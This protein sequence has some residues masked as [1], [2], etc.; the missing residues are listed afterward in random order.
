MGCPVHSDEPTDESDDDGSRGIERRS[1]L[2]SALVIGGAS[3]L[4]TTVGLYG[5][6]EEAAADDPVGVAERA[7]RQHAWQ[8]FSVFDESREQAVSPPHS[9]ALLV[10]YERPGEPAY[11]HRREVATT[12]RKLEEA[13]AWSHEGL[14]FTIGYSP[15]YFDRFDESLPD[16]LNPDGPLAKP[17]LLRARDLIDTEGVTLDRE[18]PVA[19]EYDA[20]IHM[21]SDNVQT[22][23]AAEEALWGFPGDGSR[24]S[25]N[26]VDFSEANLDGIFTKPTSYPER[27]TAHAG[28]EAVTERLEEDTEFDASRIHDDAELSMGFVDIYRNSNPRETAA[29][30]VEGQRLVDPKPPR[31][32]AQGSVEHISHLDVNLSEKVGDDD[33]GWYDD[34]DLEERRAQMF[35]PHHTDEN[36]GDVGEHLGNSNAPG[37]IPM[38]DISQV[39]NTDDST[40]DLREETEPDDADDETDRKLDVAERVEDDAREYGRIGHAQK[41]ARAR[42]DLS[43]RLTDDAEERL[44]AGADAPHPADEPED[45]VPGH[46]DDQEAEPVL[47]RRDGV[48]TS[49]DQPGNMFLALMRFNPYMVYMRRAMNGVDFDTSTFGLPTGE[50]EPGF[51]HGNAGDAGDGEFTHDEVSVPDERNGIL[52]YVTTKSRGNFLVPPITHRALP[53]PEPSTPDVEVVKDGTTYLVAVDLNS[54][55]TESGYA[56]QPERLL[57]ETVRFGYYRHVNRGGGATPAFAERRGE[58]GR[59]VFG[60]DAAETELG[61]DDR[62]R[63]RLVGKFE[64][65]RRPIFATVTVDS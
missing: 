42:F 20:A 17:A 37:D 62:T 48:S 54:N 5:M 4:S 2:K 8:A 11:E 19:D 53:Y 46:D 23:L 50:G 13:F 9:M 52:D 34:H 18:D 44:D 65:T 59:F 15:E 47:L 24:D 1:F 28:N 64:G 16:G 27:R 57:D 35:S 41:C 38:R 45:E 58:A 60:F 14:L 26:G 6:P 33:G 30:M 32:F 36:T 40:D 51:V 25:I 49:Q 10:D 21:S 39:E 56:P 29:T 43:A 12:L 31:H 63:G 55:D 3:A 61:D 22:L 7:N